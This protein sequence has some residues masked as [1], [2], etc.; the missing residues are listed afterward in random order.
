MI[1]FYTCATGEVCWESAC[2]ACNWS[3][4]EKMYYEHYATVPPLKIQS[5]SYF[6]KVLTKIMSLRTPKNGDEIFLRAVFY[7]IYYG[8]L[9]VLFYCQ[10]KSV[11]VELWKFSINF[12][13]L[14]RSGCNGF[15]MN[16]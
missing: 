1:L 5:T 7:I 16:P 14:M 2:S 15:I 11:R 4:S 13:K 9:E 6:L 10:V 8:I 12:F 3:C